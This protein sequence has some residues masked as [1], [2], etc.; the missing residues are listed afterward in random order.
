[1]GTRVSPP[2]AIGEQVH[3]ERGLRGLYLQQFIKQY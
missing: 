3:F 1:M 2:R